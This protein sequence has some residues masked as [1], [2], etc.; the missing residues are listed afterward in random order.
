LA[1]HQK[2]SEKSIKFLLVQINEAHSSAWPVGLSDQP[3]PHSCYKDRE[4]R[5]KEFIEKDQPNNPFIIRVDG[6]DNLADNTFRLW[7][8]KY[9]LIDHDYKVL[10]KAEYGRDADALINVDCIELLDNLLK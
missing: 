9:Y 7:P 6:W 2:M 5:A 4:S 3:E 10:V 8:D 1:L